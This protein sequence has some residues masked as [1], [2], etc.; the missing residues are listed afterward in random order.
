[1][2]LLRLVS[3]LAV[4]TFST[5]LHAVTVSD[6]G[7]NGLPGA[8][9]VVVSPNG[10]DGGDGESISVSA[11]SPDASNTAY[12]IGGHG[13]SGG[14]AENGGI[15]GDGGSGG[16]AV[17]ILSFSLISKAGTHELSSLKMAGIFQSSKRP[18]KRSLVGIKEL[19]LGI[20]LNN[21]VIE[22][23]SFSV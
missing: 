11:S 12:A 22:I 8:D 1:M 18:S 7:L 20:K 5:N 4:L 15:A 9:G 19:V 2:I 17:T 21:L 23:T 13:G 6:Y 10:T 3:A 16:N 14:A